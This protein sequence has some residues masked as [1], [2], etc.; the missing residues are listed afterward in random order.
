[1]DLRRLFDVFQFINKQISQI[2]LFSLGNL[3]SYRLDEPLPV[4]ELLK[5]SGCEEVR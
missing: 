4:V 3:G 1:M 5:A 2:I